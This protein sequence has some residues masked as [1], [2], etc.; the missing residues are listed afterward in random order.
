VK[1]VCGAADA[2]CTS[3]VSRGEAHA[4]TQKEIS[5]ERV[6]RRIAI[7]TI[8]LVA[9]QAGAEGDNNYDQRMLDVL[10]EQGAITQSQYEELSG[11][12]AGSTAQARPAS[13]E[14]DDPESWKAYWKNGFRVERNDGLFA[15][16]FGG[17]IHLDVAGI[18][19]DDAMQVAY[20]DLRGIGVEFRRARLFMEGEFFEHGI[21]KAQYDFAG[22]SSDN[23]IAN[24]KDLYIGLRK[25]PGVGT[26]L[27]GHQKEA[28]SLNEM[29]SSK[30]I[31][32]M[33]RA[34]P[35]LAF[36][37]SRNTGLAFYNTA[38]DKR[39]T[40][41]I[42]GFRGD[43]PD[44]EARFDNQSVYNVTGRL[45]GLPVYADEG[46]QLVHLGFAYSHSFSN[47]GV[48]FRARP[49]AHLSPVRFVDTGAVASNGLDT[50]GG[51]FAAVM[52][53]FYAQAEAIAAM[54][55]GSRTNSDAT[56]WG[57]YGQV[58]YFLTGES[59]KYK[60]SRGVFDRVSPKNRFSLK[61]GGWGAWELAARYSYLDLNDKS[62]RGGI[63]SDVTLG[64]NWY[65]YSNLRMMF[66]W[67]HAHENGTGDA[68][69]AQARLSLDF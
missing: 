1:G 3:G 2:L 68:D 37:P 48:S 51:E 26:A 20:P 64:L 40:W 31:T 47:D 16:K 29:T 33:E 24:L 69:I 53:P 10:L 52:G 18:A 14:K 42:G 41:A 63:Q 27:F 13:A 54:V 35:V 5:L 39:M 22:T 4:W 65:L 12:V 67:V 58:S 34:L 15:L 38:F 6:I 36:A 17:R 45:T 60:T 46:R 30:Y 8:S 25:L 44:G 21:F 43:T 56:F 59:K 61:D 55:N 66:N 19:A 7:L 62:I 11:Q 9:L 57:G 50:L 23:E 32:F 28:F 49:E